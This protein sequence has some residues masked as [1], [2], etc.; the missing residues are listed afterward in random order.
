MSCE[1]H[2]QAKRKLLLSAA[3]LLGVAGLFS[4]HAMLTT[5]SQA[6]EPTTFSPSRSLK[7]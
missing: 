3:A 4:T 6:G 7:P 5:A 2:M 1:E